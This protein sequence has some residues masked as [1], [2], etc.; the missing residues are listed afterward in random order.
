[1]TAGEA[2]EARAALAAI[3]RDLLAATQ[4]AHPKRWSSLAAPGPAAQCF[5]DFDTVPSWLRLS[6]PEL[7]NL[8]RRVALVSM[9]TALARSIDGA[10]LRR[11]A[12]TC[13]EDALDAAIAG[14]GPTDDQPIADADEIT[15]RGFA[16]LAAATPA[17]L[18]SYLP[19]VAPATLPADRVRS[20]IARAERAA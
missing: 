11:L 19:A 10:Q 12:E 7:I 1:M 9:A 2:R 14:A 3:G 8:A 4:P 18:R 13:G 15:D 6:A 16:L 17:A 5:R 20:W